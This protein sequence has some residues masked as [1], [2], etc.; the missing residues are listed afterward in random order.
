M[1]FEMNISVIPFASKNKMYY[2]IFIINNEVATVYN[3]FDILPVS[4]ENLPDDVV[5]YIVKYKKL[6]AFI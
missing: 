6:V 2:T 3:G 4:K 5:N 1:S